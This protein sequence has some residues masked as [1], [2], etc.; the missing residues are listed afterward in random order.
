MVLVYLH[1]HPIQVHLLQVI[2]TQQDLTLSG[3][4]ISL[5][6]Q[7]GNVDLTTLLGSYGGG[8]SNLVEDTSPQLGGALDV[9]GQDIVTQVTET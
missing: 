3:N 9:N 5:S 1:L 4:V 2:V 6:G 7:T 8:L